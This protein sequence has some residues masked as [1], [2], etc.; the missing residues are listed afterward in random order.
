MDLNLQN[1]IL[2]ESHLVRLA[3]ALDAPLNELRANTDPSF[4]GLTHDV[5]SIRG[6]IATAEQTAAGHEHAHIWQHRD[7]GPRYLRHAIGAEVQFTGERKLAPD[8]PTF[9][10]WATPARVIDY[11][12]NDR[13]APYEIR[14]AADQ[15]RKSVK[16]FAGSEYLGLTVAPYEIDDDA[17]TVARIAALAVVD[18]LA[19][20]IVAKGEI[21]DAANLIGHVLDVKLIGAVLDEG[22]SEARYDAPYL[23][24]R[25]RDALMESITS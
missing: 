22:M 11:D 15:V 4:Q 21:G 3:K 8:A 24:A 20:H 12:D 2:A 18:H 23:A 6:S 10:F 16:D 14:I 17:P 9:V 7:D 25:V 5:V 1:A 19:Q 13:D